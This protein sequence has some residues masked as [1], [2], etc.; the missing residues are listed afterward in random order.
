MEVALV[1]TVSQQTWC[2]VDVMI[3]QEWRLS[4]CTVPIAKTFIHHPVQDITIW[5]VSDQEEYKKKY[6]GYEKKILEKKKKK[7]RLSL[8]LS[9]SPSS[10]LLISFFLFSFFFCS[11]CLDMSFPFS[12]FFYDYFVSSSSLSFASRISLP[13]ASNI[14]GSC[15]ILSHCIRGPQRLYSEILNP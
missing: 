9:L 4:S 6:C 15:L 1:R 14:V 13:P 5:M 12:L 3:F 2:H 7:D 10:S 8:L 11:H